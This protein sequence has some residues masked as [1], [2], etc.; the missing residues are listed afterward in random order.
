[1]S[2][3]DTLGLNVEESRPEPIHYPSYYNHM[4]NE[5]LLEL[6][7]VVQ[8]NQDSS[9]FEAWSSGIERELKKRNLEY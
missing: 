5:R 9:V 1:M 6:W 7:N 4:S 8:K 3:Q 2:N